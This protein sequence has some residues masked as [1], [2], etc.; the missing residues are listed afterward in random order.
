[1]PGSASVQKRPGRRFESRAA[2]LHRR[3]TTRL[4]LFM[5]WIYLRALTFCAVGGGL[6]SKRLVFVAK[7]NYISFHTISIS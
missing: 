3:E 4:I 6:D 7:D 5:R 2:H 1:M